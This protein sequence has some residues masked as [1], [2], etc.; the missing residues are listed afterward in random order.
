MYTVYRDIENIAEVRF[1]TIQRVFKRSTYPEVSRLELQKCKL[2]ISTKNSRQNYSHA[3][4]AC[5]FEHKCFPWQQHVM[6]K[7]ATNHSLPGA[8]YLQ[9]KWQWGSATVCDG[10][11]GGTIP[12]LTE[13]TNPESDIWCQEPRVYLQAIPGQRHSRRGQK[14]NTCNYRNISSSATLWMPGKVSVSPEVEVLPV[15]ILDSFWFFFFFFFF[16]AFMLRRGTERKIHRIH[17]G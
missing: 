5:A 2:R 12:I 9:R 14:E 13:S 10:R 17:S 16:A 1:A 15:H 4:N 7:I 3:E 6:R 8:L 11:V